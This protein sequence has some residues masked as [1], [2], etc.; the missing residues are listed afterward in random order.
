MLQV[1]IEVVDINDNAPT[2][3][4]SQYSFVVLENVPLDTS[5]LNV[6]ATDPDSG[7]GGRVEYELVDTSEAAGKENKII[8]QNSMN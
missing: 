3:S 2:F 4:S 6:S 5:V 1:I 8:F 7:D